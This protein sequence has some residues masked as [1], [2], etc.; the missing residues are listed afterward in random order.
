M[1]SHNTI[2]G[3]DLPI[4]YLQLFLCSFFT[5]YLTSSINK[6]NQS[7]PFPTPLF[8]SSSSRLTIYISMTMEKFQQFYVEVVFLLFLCLVISVLLG[9]FSPY[10]VTISE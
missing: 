4:S 5:N 7:S 6:I 3:F 2:E 9:A 1:I 10:L 8:S